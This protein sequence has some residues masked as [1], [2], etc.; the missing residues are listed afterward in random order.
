MRIF[1]KVCI[2]VLFN[3]FSFILIFLP[4]AVAGW[5]LV[6]RFFGYQPSLLFM[7]CM[8]FIFYGKFQASFA[9][10]LAISILVTYGLSTGMTFCE[11]KNLQ[12]RKV[13]VVLGV[14][15]QLGLLFL[16]KYLDFFADTLHS[17]TGIS[18][19][20]A[21]FLMP[22]GIS[23][24]TFQQLSYLIDRYRGETEQYS[25]L[26][27]ATY[28]S[29]FPKLVEGPIAFHQEMIAQFRNEKCRSFDLERFLQGSSLFII[30]MAKKVLLAD[31]LSAAVDYGFY[32]THYMDTIT[33]VIVLLAY[34][35]QIYFDFS[36]YCDM[37]TGISLMM[38]IDLPVNFNSP[39]KAVTSKEL[40]QRW[41]MTLSRF[42]VKYVY[43][44]LGGSRKGKLRTVCNVLLVFFLSGIWHGAGWT[45]MAW[46]LM[47]GLLVVWDDLGIV[48]VK[49]P[50]AKPT[51]TVEAAANAMDEKKTVKKR[52]YLLREKPLIVVP[53]WVGHLFTFSMFVLSLVFFRSESMTYAFVYFK[54]LFF[55]TWP[56][57]LYR[58]VGQ[59]DLSE[60][61]VVNQAVSRLAPGLADPVQTILFLL[62]LVI[63]FIVITRPNAREI[64]LKHPF[65]MKKALALGILFVWSYLSM[66]GVSTFIY[67]QF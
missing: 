28:V 46:G 64:A 47:Q 38:G 22:I 1:R 32:Y 30:G 59:M 29:Y 14:L 57:F 19:P 35:F 61:Y 23:F 2:K 5:Y 51:V 43:I 63:C 18:L 50:K 15:F 34:T 55:F 45:Y 27:Y 33:G 6:N 44:P 40:W 54:R 13:L 7:T 10:I 60:M 62:L 11:K 48:A 49:E 21:S 25:L 31:Q 12:G 67:F 17:I 16:Y 37:A 3:S 56:G 8:S 65:T 58:T 26:E 4:I 42:F 36:G 9:L 41:H 52:R 20:A 39:Y 66:S 24:I 53:R